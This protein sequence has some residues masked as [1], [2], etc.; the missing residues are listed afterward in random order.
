MTAKVVGPTAAGVE[1]AGRVL[2]S[3]GLVAFPTETVYGLGANALD[4]AAVRRIFAVKE[5]PL[6]DPLIV[7]VAAP[8]DAKPLVDLGEGTPA[9]AAFAALAEAFWP[10]PLT[11]VCPARPHLPKC[12]SAGTGTVGVRCPAHPLA[13]RLIAA[14]GV[15]VAAPSANKFGH[16]SPTTAQHV[17]DDLGAEEISVLDAGPTGGAC[18]HG[19]E[20]TVVGVAADGA[21]TLHRRGAVAREKIEAVAKPLGAKVAVADA[22]K[23][24]DDDA[25]CAPGQLLTHYAPRLPAALATVASDAAADDAKSDAYLGA[26]VVVD[27]HG[28]LAA[29]EKPALAY[30]DLSKTGDAAEAAAALFETLRWAEAVPDAKNV[31]LADLSEER[32]SAGLVAGVADRI[33]R[34]ASGNLIEIPRRGVLG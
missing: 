26:C 24:D 12:L 23:K 29:L 18:A 4:E 16:V 13:R 28:R 3:G 32:A 8:D 5:R 20:S 7:H 11:L 6:S 10:G 9:A 2:A 30:R 31:F 34:A 22:Y 1:A 14:A 25:A 33:F 15:P 21:L 19:I 27:F 17:L